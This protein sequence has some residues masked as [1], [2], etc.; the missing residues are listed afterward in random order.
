[1]ALEVAERIGNLVMLARSPVPPA[2]PRQGA[3]ERLRRRVW[4]ESILYAVRRAHD[5]GFGWIVVDFYLIHERMVQCLTDD[6]ARALGCYD[7]SREVG[8][9][10]RYGAGADVLGEAIDGRLSMLLFGQ[11]GALG[12]AVID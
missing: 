5:A 2:D 6:I 9:K 3:I 11:A 1:M 12:H 10:L 7:A 8:V 4:P